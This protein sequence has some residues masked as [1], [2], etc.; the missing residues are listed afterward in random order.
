[1][2]VATTAIDVCLKMKHI[3]PA[4]PPLVQRSWP[5]IMT[6]RQTI[7]RRT[8][9]RYKPSST[10][11]RPRPRLSDPNHTDHHALEALI[12]IGRSSNPALGQL[13]VCVFCRPTHLLMTSKKHGYCT[14][15]NIACGNV[16]SVT[17][18][19]YVA[20]RT[21]GHGDKFPLRGC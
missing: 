4:S 21:S 7:Y 17:V 20:G 19:L 9:L 1:M 5:N 3:D 13:A 8:L 18:S 2:V 11:W 15:W 12:V 16:G 10:P 14:S 6:D